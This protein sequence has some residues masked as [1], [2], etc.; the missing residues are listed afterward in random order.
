CIGVTGDVSDTNNSG[1][2]RHGHCINGIG[3]EG[4]NIWGDQRV[5]CVLCCDYCAVFY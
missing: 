4:V 5:N 1:D 2:Q 3:Q